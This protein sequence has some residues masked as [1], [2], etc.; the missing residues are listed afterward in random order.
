M[1]SKSAKDNGI[2]ELYDY[3]SKDNPSIHLFLK[4]GFELLEITEKYFVVRKKL[5]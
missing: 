2:L 3:I 1:L 5:S 4:N